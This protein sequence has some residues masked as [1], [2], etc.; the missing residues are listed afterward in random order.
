MPRWEFI[1]DSAAVASRV[2]FLRVNGGGGGGGDVSSVPADHQ[3]ANPWKPLR[4][5]DCQSLNA[6][7]Y[8]S[9]KTSDGGGDIEDDSRSD[10]PV[11]IDG[12]RLAAYPEE[13]IVR[14]NYLSTVQYELCS[15]IW[16]RREEKSKKEVLLHPIQDSTESQAIEG[17]YQRVVAATSSLGEGLASVANETI[18]LEPG[19]RKV[20][21]NKSPLK[22]ILKEKGWFAPQYDLQRGYGEYK[23]EGEEEELQLGEVGH[24]VFVVHGI[25]EA[26]FS[27]QDVNLP[28]IAE[29]M[30]ATRLLIQKQQVAEHKAN[31]AKLKPA[32]SDDNES[33]SAHL[34]PAPER[35]EI[36]PIEW[37]HRVHDSSSTLMRS[38]RSTTLTTIPALRAIANDVIFD[39]LMYLT[40]KFCQ[41]V[42]ECV[43]EQ[44][45]QHYVTFLTVNPHFHGKCSLIGH[46]LGSVICWDLLSVLQQQRGP[47][48]S[49]M[50]GE[51]KPGG[52]KLH[53]VS[54]PSQDSV[55]IG[56]QAYATGDASCPAD[57]GGSTEHISS[58]MA[59]H[60]TWGPT[61]IRPMRQTIP[62]MPECTVFLGSPLGLFLTLRGAHAVFESLRQEEIASLVSGRQPSPADLE[63]I[64]RRVASPFHLPTHHLYNIFN[65]SDPVAYRIEPLLLSPNLDP[66]GPD[67]PPPEYLTAV[68]KDVRLHV[69]ARQIADDL[70]RTLKDQKNSW[71]ALLDSTLATRAALQD[72][73]SSS[74]ASSRLL[75][76]GKDASAGALAVAH[77]PL[78]SWPPTFALGCPLHPKRVDYSF[79]PAI[80]ENEY[81]NAVTAHSSYFSNSD[82][83]EFLISKLAKPPGLTS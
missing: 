35:I 45:C 18:T 31:L 68:G 19:E 17:F 15:A 49:M 40:P 7:F 80:V 60:G 79:Q 33:G 53:P 41:S 23:V 59:E 56:Y 54:I 47:S 75:Q 25:G 21:L 52:S 78:P 67:F 82:F 32:K 27:K 4:K 57:V 63:T 11:Y 55:E 74:L 64:Q 36:I 3:Q 38:L 51:T 48:S 28:G 29:Q 1:E 43:T 73:S 42:L 30:N 24:V 71:N 65:P 62:F 37:F 8:P 9:S 2:W 76:A 46:S 77:M 61:L 12:G 22:L 44:I 58:D 10:S 39:V 83:Q 5:C 70:Q 6:K 16:F 72:G 14:H 26:F 20:V 69:R 50:T 66:E 13:G 34:P 81:I